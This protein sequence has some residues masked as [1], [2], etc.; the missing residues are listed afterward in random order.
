[1][2]NTIFGSPADPDETRKLLIESDGMSNSGSKI[3]AGVIHQFAAAS[4]RRTVHALRRK[5]VESDVVFEGDPMPDA[6]NRDANFVYPA[7]VN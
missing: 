7:I 1:M 5:C 4:A 3:D 2:K 6:F